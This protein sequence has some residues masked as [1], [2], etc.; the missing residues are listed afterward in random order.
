MILLLL[1]IGI[2]S[3]TIAILLI[4]KTGKKSK[5]ENKEKV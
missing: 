2:T 5:V 4:R 3:G 1:G